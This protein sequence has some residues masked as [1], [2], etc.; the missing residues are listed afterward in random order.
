MS[1]IGTAS[2]KFEEY[3]IDRARWQLTWRDEPIQLTRKTFDLLLY[4]VDHADRVVTKDELLRTLWPESFVEESNLTQHIFLLRKALSPHHSGARI[5]ETVPG[6]GYRFV[7]AIKLKPPPAPD[8]MVITAAES[9]TRF[10][11]EEEEEVDSPAPTSQPAIRN[12]PF[13]APSVLRRVLWITAAAV[14]IATICIAGWIARQRWLDRTGG[15]PVDVV[16]TPFDGTTGDQILDRALT[17]ALRMDLAQSPFVSVVSSARVRATLTQMMHKPDDPMSPVMA[18]EVC[19][20]TNSQGVLSG[21][22]SR[23]GQHFL[24]TE[25]ASNC[26]DGS[27][28]AAAKFEATS[29]EDLPR[30]IDKLAARLRQKLGESR[31]SIARFNTPLFATNTVSLEALKDYSQAIRQGDEGRFPEAITLI[32]KAIAADPKFAAAYYELAAYYGSNAD[33]AS[34]RDALLKAQ[35]IVD[36]A[37]EPVRFAIEALYSSATTED[38]Y[39][40]ERNYRNWTELYPR[41]A[42]A[43]NGLSN[44]QSN[45]GK[46]AESAISAA[47][48]LA[49]RPT[50]Q[51]MYVNLVIEQVLSGDAKSAQVTCENAIAKGLDGDRVREAYLFTS[52][53][54]ND[55]ALIQA[56]RNWASAHPGSTYFQIEEV[57]LAFRDGRFSDAHRLLAQV[58]TTFR[59]QGLEGVADGIVKTEGVNLMEAGDLDEGRRLFQS[60]P[61]DPEE[62][63]QVVGLALAGDIAQ[64]EA[65]L[66]TMQLKYPKGTIWNLYTAP[67]IHAFAAMA[68]HRPKVAIAALEI[69]RSLEGRDLGHQ[70]L[71]ADAYLA[72][73]DPADAEKE[74][75]RIISRRLLDPVAIEVPL[76]WLGLARALAAERNRTAA[77]DAYQHFFALWAHADPD[78]K[79][80]QQATQEFTALQRLAPPK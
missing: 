26:V 16:L 17:D 57:E 21:N 32:K 30:A 7:A 74:F 27:L 31:R 20:R 8:R 19:E 48:A 9:I 13:S 4:L 69:S 18:R 68:V 3:E 80:L 40:S 44:V 67:F 12:S 38:L 28:V 49:L 43:W 23:V 34:E 56:Q 76:S 51:G 5:I 46:H 41:S 62:N 72:A 59:E 25:E 64:S 54:M 47:H 55:S 71:R 50:N 6:R 2:I 36:S 33:F 53:A 79:F 37:G 66:H 11:L 70:A 52:L 60:K 77:L 35:S 73:G 58:A 42:P 63:Y 15:P 75:R 29:L 65:T 22:I 14:A 78:A 1:F 61:I 45:L 24:I 10:T 39:A